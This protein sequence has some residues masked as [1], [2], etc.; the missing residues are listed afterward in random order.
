M[1]ILILL[2]T[3]FTWLQ[4]A[5]AARGASLRELDARTLADI[6]IDAS[7]FGSIDAEWHRAAAITRRRIAVQPSHA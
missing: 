3:L 5:N 1:T 4:K 2:Q 7:E 6:G